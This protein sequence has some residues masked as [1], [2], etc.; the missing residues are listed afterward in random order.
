MTD[1]PM[2]EAAQ[3]MA[4]TWSA[5]LV[6]VGVL[7]STY[8]YLSANILGAPRILFAMAEHG[9][10]PPAMARVHSR[11]RTPHLAIV[12]FAILL[13]L[14][15][16]AGN[17]EWNVFISAVRVFFIMGRFA[18]LCPCCAANQA[19]H[20]SNF[21]LLLAI[22]LRYSRSACLCCFFLSSTAAG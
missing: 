22:S 3:V 17:F 7:F 16:I 5:A 11:F 12:V 4:G 21:I 8:G 19:C 20:A 9:D 15:A 2:A 18:R 10:V 1:R 14:C 6:S 13:Y